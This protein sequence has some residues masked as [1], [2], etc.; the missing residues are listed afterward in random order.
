[1]G[2]DSVFD[3]TVSTRSVGEGNSVR[4]SVSSAIDRSNVSSAIVAPATLAAC[5]R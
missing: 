3:S 5:A 4:S 2:P 1:M